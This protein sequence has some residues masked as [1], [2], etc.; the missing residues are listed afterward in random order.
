MDLDDAYANA[1][2]IPNAETYPPAWAS[3]AEA[4]RKRLAA[5]GR[6]R[7]GLMY[8]H[9]TRQALDLF[10]PE[11]ASKGLA[12]FVHGGYWLKFDRSSWSHLA[13][14]ARA[15]GW[16]VAV[17]SYDL[18]PRVRISDITRQVAQAVAVAAREVAGPLRLAGHSAGGHLVARLAMPGV[19]P[20]DV[21]E[22][23]VR[24]M[25]IS[26]V[27]DL[28]P[29][30]KTAMN[31]D[32]KLD[33]AEARAESPALAPAPAVPVTVWVGAKERPVFLDQAAG[34]ARAWG[35]EH[36]VDP[37]RHHFDVIDPMGEPGSA[38]VAR[39]LA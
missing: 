1:P 28:R 3:A 13:E 25:P 9:G 18:A 24:V 34:L 33:A 15:A 5:G 20:G 6:A 12:V 39:W 7:L 26:P 27:A 30:M 19:L 4:Y 31:A 35:A 38:M 32:L 37:G 8:G 36:V 16:S 14:G 23:I 10:L 2:Y 21:A 11:G 29:L 17:P 22:R